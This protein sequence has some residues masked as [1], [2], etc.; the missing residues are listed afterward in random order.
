[1]VVT[2]SWSPV[3]LCSMMPRMFAGVSSQI[4][5]LRKMPVLIFAKLVVVVAVVVA[6]Q[7]V[8]VPMIAAPGLAT[9]L[10]YTVVAVSVS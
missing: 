3:L 4:E 6:M 10:L 2:C 7:H 9:A 5:L 8:V 1:M